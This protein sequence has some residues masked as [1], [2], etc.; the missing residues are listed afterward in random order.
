LDV[1]DESSI[2]SAL[3]KIQTTVPSLN[4]LINVAAVLQDD[5]HSIKPERRASEFNPVASL[6]SF[7][8]NAI[9]PMLMAKHFLPMLTPER[10]VTD[11]SIFVNFSARVGSIAD[12]GSGGWA[13]YRS[14]KAA[15]NQFLKTLH[16]EFS[17]K[18]VAVVSIHPGTVDTDLT[19][20]FL[21]ARQKYDVQDVDEAA[22]NL[23]TMFGNFTVKEHSGKFFDH[24]GAE[25]PW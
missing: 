7:Q 6:R 10:G 12:N 22:N 14:S 13:T 24:K 2:T 18:N 17:R 16:H 20:A 3:S 9:G 4:C 1:T 15:A 11:P 19:R 23:A 5:S 21:K 25:I 8:V